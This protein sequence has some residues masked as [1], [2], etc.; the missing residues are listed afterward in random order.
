MTLNFSEMRKTQVRRVWL[1]MKVTNHLLSEEVETLG[2]PQISL[3]T[4]VKGWVD[5]YDCEEKKTRCCLIQ[6]HTPQDM[7]QVSTLEKK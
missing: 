7:V 4:R 3:W 1:L 6:I 2:S 5:L